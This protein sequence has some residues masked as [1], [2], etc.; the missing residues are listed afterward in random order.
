MAVIPTPKGVIVSS[1]EAVHYTSDM[2]DKFKIALYHHT[3]SPDGTGSMEVI[4][5][6]CVEVPVRD[7][8][9]EEGISRSEEE[10]GTFVRTFGHRIE[11]NYHILL[12]TLEEHGLNPEEYPRPPHPRAT[13]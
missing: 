8:L 1:D 2:N 7:L 6:R 12:N 3:T 11:G 5:S 13:V 4:P 9:E 10:L